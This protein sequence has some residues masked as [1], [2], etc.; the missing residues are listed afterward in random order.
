MIIFRIFA[1]Q[2]RLFSLARTHSSPIPEIVLFAF[3]V[4]HP[5]ESSAEGNLQYKERLYQLGA[6]SDDSV[7]PD[8]MLPDI[9]GI[10]HRISDYRG[11]VVV[12]NFWSTW[13]IPCREEMPSLERAWKRLKP[14][15]ALILAVALQDEVE[16]VHRFLQN[17]TVSFPLLLDSDGEIAKQWRVIGIPVTF[18]LDPSGRIAY[19]ASGIREWDSDPI[20]HKI[21]ELS[22]STEKAVE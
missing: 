19:K 1:G 7:A 13:C 20:I 18:V 12:I 6:S 17:T 11:R 14:S 3:L 21:L 8:F 9:R 5:L 2:R 15:N 16:S 4:F 22:Q 10:N